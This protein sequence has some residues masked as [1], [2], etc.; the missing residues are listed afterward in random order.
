MCT[1]TL[2]RIDLKFCIGKYFRLYHTKIEISTICPL[3]LLPPSRA[4]SI[5]FFYYLPYKG[6][7]KIYTVTYKRDIN[8]ILSFYHREMDSV[9]MLLP[10]PHHKWTDIFQNRNEC[11]FKTIEQCH[12]KFGTCPC[13]VFVYRW[14]KTGS[15]HIVDRNTRNILR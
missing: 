10:I 3:L 11:N 9:V 15:I 6:C 7:N 13:F 5:H 1:V 12:M 14:I 8:F 2:E 4:L